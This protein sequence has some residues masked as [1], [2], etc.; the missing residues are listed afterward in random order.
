MTKSLLAIS[1]A[2]VLLGTSVLAGDDHKHTH[3]INQDGA[4]LSDADSAKIASFDILAAHAHRNGNVVTFHMTTNGLAG[5]DV[6]E[7]TGAV[8]G[9]G[10]L[11]YVWPTSLDPSAVGFE[12]ETGIL[13]LAATS[14]PDFDDTP[15]YDENGDGDPANDGIVWH[16]HW[17]VLTPTETCGPGALA[18]RDIPEGETP[19]LPA[20]W[21]GFPILLD[22]PGF[23]PLFDGPE[24]AINV[25][26]KSGVELDGMSYDG[27]TSALRVNANVHS[28]LLCVVD[29]FDIA[30]GDL[31]LPGVVN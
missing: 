11:S 3:A 13:A 19:Q 5:A 28:P 30:S 24:I 21:P 23:T 27:V 22:S 17:V 25:G 20:T 12:Q 1:S 26:F 9:A 18:V 4:I 7:A 31:S 6:P 29:V 16:S 14:H 2:L 15:L 8:G 10:V